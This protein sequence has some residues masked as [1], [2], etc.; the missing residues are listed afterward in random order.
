MLDDEGICLS[1]R[2]QTLSN[3][4]GAFSEVTLIHFYVTI[5]KRLLWYYYITRIMIKLHL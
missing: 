1:N 2:N 5:A 4:W 3:H